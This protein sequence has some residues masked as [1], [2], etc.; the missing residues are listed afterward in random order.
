MLSDLDRLNLIKNAAEKIQRV[1]VSDN[2]DNIN[3]L[4]D[5]NLEDIESVDIDEYTLIGDDQSKP[6]NFN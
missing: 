2:I 4:L 6:L 3:G 5:D 1:N